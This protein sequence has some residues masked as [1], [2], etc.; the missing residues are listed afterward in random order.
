MG[1]GRTTIRSTKSGT[2]VTTRVKNGNT[3]VTTTTGAGKKP[4]KTVSTRVGKT[5][6]TKT[7]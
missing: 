6:Y 2:R 3:T 4:R 1:I 7:Y 5:T